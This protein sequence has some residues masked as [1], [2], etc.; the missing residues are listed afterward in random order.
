MTLTTLRLLLPMA[1]SGCVFVGSSKASDLKVPLPGKSQV[2]P[3]QKLNREGVQEL[4]R[5]HQD[6]AKRYFYRAYLL[7]P[8]DPFTLNNLGYI[9]ELEGDADRALRYYELST[10]SGSEAVIAIATRPDLKGHEIQDAFSALRAPELKSNKAN[11]QAISLLGQGRVTE[12]E[13][14]LSKSLAEDPKNPFT[15]NN[16]GYVMEIEGD[17]QGAVKYYSAAAAGRSQETVIIAPDPKWRGRPISKVALDN[18]RQV[19]EII[20][21]GEDLNARVA[22]LN[23]RGVAAVNRNDAQTARQ[24]FEQ[25]Y[26]LN[27]HDAFTLNN[28][29]YVAEMNGDQ[30]TA[31]TYYQEAQNAAGGSARVTY[32]TRRQA[33]GLRMSAVAGD[34]ENDMTSRIEALQQLRRRR[35]G[36]IELKRRGSSSNEP[37]PAQ[38]P[39]LSQRPASQDIDRKQEPPLPGVTPPPLPTPPLPDRSTPPQA[40]PQQTQPPQTQPQQ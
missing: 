11:V 33:E 21:K 17:L 15:L 40:Q 5:H 27:P 24:L 9:S 30:E 39:A 28:M 26:R 6:K 19:S 32:A 31:E 14:A 36:P 38:Q 25:A 1:F 8:N 20:A 23:M 3:V 4:R 13:Q 22:R 16:L 12:A 7:D 35:G 34:N 37:S 10:Q 18:S 2:T 29:G